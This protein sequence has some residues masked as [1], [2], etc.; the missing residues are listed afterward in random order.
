MKIRLVGAELFHADGRTDMKNITVA[1]RTSAK[2]LNKKDSLSANSFECLL[3]VGN[4]I[5]M[6]Y[7]PLFCF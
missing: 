3:Y 4:V 2:G 5:I 1:F 7:V 6:L